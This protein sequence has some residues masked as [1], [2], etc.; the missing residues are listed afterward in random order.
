MLVAPDNGYKAKLTD[1]G[2]SHLLDALTANHVQRGTPAYWAPELLRAVGGNAEEAAALDYPSVDTYAYGVLLCELWSEGA[3]PFRDMPRPYDNEENDLMAAVCN[4][5]WRPSVPPGMPEE[6]AAL[7]RSCWSAE[8]AERPTFE[9]VC[10]TLAALRAASSAVPART[11]SSL[12]GPEWPL[13]AATTAA[14]TATTRAQLVLS[15]KPSVPRGTTCQLTAQFL[16][17]SLEQEPLIGPA[18]SLNDDGTLRVALGMHVA[19]GDSCELKLHPQDGCASWL[20]AANARIEFG[21]TVQL[22]IRP[23]WEQAPRLPACGIAAALRVDVERTAVT[24][25]GS[26]RKPFPVLRVLGSVSLLLAKQEAP[27]VRGAWPSAERVC[28]L[29][30]MP[31]LLRLGAPKADVF[32]SY[33]DT[34][35]GMR[36]NNGYAFSVQSELEAAGYS[37]FCYATLIREGSAWVNV[38]QHGLDACAAFVPI[39]SPEYGDLDISPWTHNE[40]LYGTH[41]RRQLGAPAIVPLWH[42]GAY[43]PADTAGLLTPDLARVPAGGT[44]ARDLDFGAVMKELLAALANAGVKGTL[45]PPPPHAA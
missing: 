5:G 19:A 20:G 30:R 15:Y 31:S 2:T 26:R 12:G 40:V 35:T 9:T 45:L 32:I 34:E 17:E 28:C 6:Y 36:S 23:R 8:P 11:R 37:V 3:S 44:P 42:H 27:R 22:V 29:S 39:C 41:R 25:P 14:R 1:F 43:P 10:D 13:A 24:E 4:D 33:R 38:L 16:P 18:H 21:K 7:M